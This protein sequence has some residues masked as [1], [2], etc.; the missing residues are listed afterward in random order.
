MKTFFYADR[1]V[2]ENGEL[3]GAVVEENG[4]ILSVGKETEK[5]QS[6]DRVYDLRGRIL[7]P[8][9]LEM[10]S[11]GAGGH[12]FT[13]TSTE[14][15]AAG[16][17]FLLAHGAT[18]L[19]PTVTTGPFCRMAEAARHIRTVKEQQ[20]SRAH[21]LGVHLEGP[22]LSRRQAGGQCA[23]YI[24]VPREEEYLPFLREMR[25]VL[26]RWDFAPEQDPR[27]SFAKALRDA[28]VL[29]AAAHTDATYEEMLPAL[30]NGL[31][32]I[33]HLY[34]CTSTVTRKGGFRSLGV[35]ETAFLMDQLYVEIIAD[36][37]HL[38]KELIQMI[39]KIKGRERTAL[40][41]DSLSIAGMDVREGSMSGT[42]YIVEDG[43]CKLKDRS[44][45]A[46]SV[47]TP[48]RLLAVMTQECGFSL[49][50]AVYMA[51]TTPANILSLPNKGRIS[52]G[53]DADLVVLNENLSV[54]SVFVC[55][56]RAV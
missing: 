43:V 32:L 19:L 17:D 3:S 51:A 34:S 40:I 28:D 31:S 33:T 6:G 30:E 26:R 22:Y 20:L 9:L 53:A 12:S 37:K 23:D 13:D 42:N 2:T 24:T 11:H 27:G 25:G 50:D 7:I 35:I 38:P 14:E 56:R 21:V 46:G 41:T 1:I 5:P 4:T 55:G 39:V 49:A 48:D 29:A 54:D 8:G 47:A 44:A 18:S 10:H 16:C 52:P 15:V 45:F 36:G